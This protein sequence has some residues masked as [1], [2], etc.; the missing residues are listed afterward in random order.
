MRQ[1]VGNMILSTLC[2]GTGFGVVQAVAAPSPAGAASAASAAATASPTSIA[3]TVTVASSGAPLAGAEVTVWNT[4][5][6]IASGDGTGA[7][8]VGDTT[9]GA[10]GTYSVGGL[11]SAT[12][13][14]VCLDAINLDVSGPV[15]Y[16]NQ[17]YRNLPWGGPFPGGFGDIQFPTG[18]TLVPA[19]SSAV[20][21]ALVDSVSVSG[22]V[23]SQVGGVPLNG[24]GVYVFGKDGKL[25]S[26]QPTSNGSY[27]VPGATV[28]DAPYSVCFDGSTGTGGP[29]T[30]GYGSE[31]YQNV[32][33]VNGQAPAA[34][35]T[36]VPAAGVPGGANQ[37]LPSNAAPGGI[38]GQA[39]EPIL[40][41]LATLHLSGVTVH[42][43]NAADTIIGTAKTA[44]NGTYAIGGLPASPSGYAVCFDA[45][46][47]QG[48][49][50][51]GPFADQC[52]HGV[53]DPGGPH[54]P[55]SRST[56]VPVASGK[57]TPGISA[58]FV[59]TL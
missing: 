17:C 57:V 38:S 21:V 6:N 54:F 19:G 22:T 28:S 45:S 40:L 25:L 8:F 23:T 53:P 46:T 42:V 16:Q 14:F 55:S 48:G 32:P 51:L 2:A 49:I 58:V 10:D 1:R 9:S 26:S 12:N 5:G 30:A 44:A 56:L 59:P 37:A 43:F 31:C 41:G 15:Q 34:G 33:W 18:M 50:T 39:S 52:F 20:N 24:V 36:P 13:Y 27:S 3:G 29:S 35:S 47:A 4:A 11:T 7:N